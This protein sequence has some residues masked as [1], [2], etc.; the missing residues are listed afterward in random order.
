MPN[1]WGPEKVESEMISLV[2]MF[3]ATIRDRV[4]MQSAL[5]SVLGNIESKDLETIKSSLYS[6]CT[7]VKLQEYAQNLPEEFFSN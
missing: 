6:L 1:S 4:N 5:V 2:K 7:D 3:K